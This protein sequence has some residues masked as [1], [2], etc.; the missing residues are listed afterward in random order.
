MLGKHMNASIS[1]ETDDGEADKMHL[2]DCYGAVEDNKP[3]PVWIQVWLPTKSKPSLYGFCFAAKTMSGSSKSHVS[4]E[5]SL[6]WTNQADANEQHGRRDKVRI[7]VITDES[8]ED[9][10]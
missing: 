6:R 3:C 4:Q 7:S 2:M 10:F 8:K 5:N 9:V 1:N